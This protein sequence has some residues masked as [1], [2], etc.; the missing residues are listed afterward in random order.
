MA[1]GARDPVGA[2]ASLKARTRMNALRLP[3]TIAWRL[4]LRLHFRVSNLVM[5]N[6]VLKCAFLALIKQKVKRVLLW[7]VSGLVQIN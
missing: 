5:K 6:S 1:G 3:A 4:H 2:V 7:V